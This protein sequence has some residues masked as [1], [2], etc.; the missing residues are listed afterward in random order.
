MPIANEG[1]A[2]IYHLFLIISSGAFGGFLEFLNRFVFGIYSSSA[3][4]EIDE[5]FTIAAEKQFSK[6]SNLDNKQKEQSELRFGDRVNEIHSAEFLYGGLKF[7]RSHLIRIALTHILHGIGG[8]FAILFALSSI[9]QFSFSLDVENKLFLISLYVV[10]GFAGSR[11]LDQ[12]KNNIENQL[13]ENNLNMKKV[14][15]TTEELS[16]R[17]NHLRGEIA[18]EAEAG[19]VLNRA[20]GILEKSKADITKSTADIEHIARDLHDLLGRGES[21]SR[22]MLRRCAIY[23]GRIYRVH[24]DDLERGIAALEKFV[25]FS[26][27][28]KLHDEDY[29]AVMFN[30]ACYKSKLSEKD[31][32][33]NKEQL[34]AEAKVVLEKACEAS[35]PIRHQIFG[36]KEKN[37]APDPD[38]NAYRDWLEKSKK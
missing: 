33:P 17:L 10:A 20:H 3:F 37:I 34:L 23:L 8:A 26:D 11:V 14:Q 29:A 24:F 7:D 32:C 12:V 21:L 6:K 5:K 13:K 35:A 4:S 15:K 16:N 9:N 18:L 1:N 25:D 28:Q 31:D 19:D 30:I 36:F 27:A 38:L 2:L 22:L